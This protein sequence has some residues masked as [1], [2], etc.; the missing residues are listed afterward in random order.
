MAQADHASTTARA[1]FLG[2]MGYTSRRP[3]GYPPL[4][5]HAL[6]ANAHRIARSFS[7]H[8]ATYR[9]AL[10]YGLAAAWRQNRSART[11]QSLALS[12]AQPTASVV[13]MASRTP[14][15]P[16][17]RRPMLGSYGYVGA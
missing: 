15:Q 3:S 12:V 17:H 1:H 8:F 16:N 5:R 13:L 7:Q 11:I 4:D 9:E 6:M 10:A 14:Q 2:P